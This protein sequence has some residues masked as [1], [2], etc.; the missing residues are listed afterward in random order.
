MESK[1]YLNKLYF[2][3]WVLGVTHDDINEI[4]RTRTFKQDIRWIIPDSAD[5]FYADP[6]I[7]RSEKNLTEILFEDFSLDENFGNISLMTIDDDLK[8]IEKKIILDTGSHLSFPFVFKEGGRIY[9]FPESARNGRVSCYEFD[10]ITRNL[11]FR[12]DIL[13]MPLYD[14][15]ILKMEDKYWLMGSIF[16]DRKIYKLHVFYSGDLLGPYIPVSGNPVISGLDATR[17][18]GGFIEVDGEIYRPT[19][20]CSN[21]YGES[22]TIN[23]INKI[24]ETGYLEEPYMK[25]EINEKHGKGN[26]IHTIHTLNVS[27]NTIVVDGRRWAFSLKEQWR[28]FVRNRRI[29]KLEGAK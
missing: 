21:S 3:Q 26:G 16:E 13:N 18:A 2:K 17:S 23:R 8:I 20:N 9:V 25:I 5:H 4:I 19:Q 24:D 10:Q 28:N 6:F 11:L 1:G 29:L 12:G 7:V 22:I 14:P 15:S 27:G